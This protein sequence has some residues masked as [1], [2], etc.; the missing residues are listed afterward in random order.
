MN[1]KDHLNLG[2]IVIVVCFL[3]GMSRQTE[4]QRCGSEHVYCSMESH[5]QTISRNSKADYTWVFVDSE[6]KEHRVKV[7]RADRFR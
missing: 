4:V 3:V 5:N 1:W 7:E 2:L 6:G